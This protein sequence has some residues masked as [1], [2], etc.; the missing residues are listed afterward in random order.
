MKHY[1]LRSKR[2][3]IPVKYRD[4]FSDKKF[5]RVHS[6]GADTFVV[7]WQSTPNNAHGVVRES[8]KPYILIRNKDLLMLRYVTVTRDGEQLILKKV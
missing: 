8:G 6:A 4:I 7:R 5:Y 2:L 3:H 1:S